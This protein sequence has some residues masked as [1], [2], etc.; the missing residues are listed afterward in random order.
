[1]HVQSG[2]HIMEV[3][4]NVSV[5]CR[6]SRMVS[7]VVSLNGRPLIIQSYLAI[8]PENVAD[9]AASSLAGPRVT[10][11]VAANLATV[12]TRPLSSGGRNPGSAGPTAGGLWSSRPT[13]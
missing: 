8:V 6:P 4:V 1:M 3:L 7:G 11:G 10:A 2:C 13:T 9:S 12:P 5:A